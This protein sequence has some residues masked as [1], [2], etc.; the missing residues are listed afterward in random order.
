MDNK[1]TYKNASLVIVGLGIKFKSHL[2]I[3]A[4]AYIKEADKVLFLVNEP[5]M[6]EW[7]KTHNSNSESLEIHYKQ[8]RLRSDSYEAMTKH[9]LKEL[10]KNQNICVA[11]YGHPTS[12]AR[13]ALDAFIQAKEE[14]FYTKILPGISAE[15]CLFADLAINP[16]SHGC[17]SYE[18]TDFLL[19][20]RLINP[21]SHLILWQIGIIG[22]VNYPNNHNNIPGLNLL[23]K[24]LKQHYPTNHQTIFYEAAQYPH[25]EPTIQKIPLHQIETTHFTALSTLYIPPIS[26]AIYNKTTLEILELKELDLLKK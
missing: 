12:F 5:A 24:Y 19:H 9:I 10:N 23:H 15:D 26:Q 4:L 18:A 21:Y 8:Y 17:L 11:L 22:C 14:G 16:G 13:P 25:F 3:E 6:G 20:Q 7:I 1:I 2:T